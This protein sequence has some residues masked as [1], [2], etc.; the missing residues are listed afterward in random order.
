[1]LYI[2][3]TNDIKILF[4]TYKARATNVV[5]E[6]KAKAKDSHQGQGQGHIA[7]GQGQGQG[8]T[9]T[10][11]RPRPR[12]QIL[13]L[14]PRPR[15]RTNITALNSHQHTSSSALSNC[16]L[17]IRRY[18]SGWNRRLTRNVSCRTCIRMWFWSLTIIQRNSLQH[19]T[20]IRI[21]TG[22]I[23]SRD[24]LSCYRGW[25]SLSPNYQNCYY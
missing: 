20:R 6:S 23:N 25:V 10:R 13:S 14:R 11:P 9:I 7:Q 8:Q 19:S 16:L 18:S 21:L 4:F 24:N 5:L 17:I 1:M 3:T 2:Q 22:T 15:P 12:P